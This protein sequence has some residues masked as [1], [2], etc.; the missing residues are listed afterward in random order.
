V[1]LA[2]IR[3]V[4]FLRFEGVHEIKLEPGAYS[5][6]ARR[7][8]DAE[9]SNWTGKSTI[10]QAVRF[11]L[12]GTIPESCLNR[13]VDGWITEGQ[14]EGEVALWFDDQGGIRRW[15]EPG[16]STQLAAGWVPGQEPA[17]QDAAQAL[18]LQKVGLSE[19]DWMSTCYLEQGAC[20]Q[21]VTE[22]AG[23]RTE[24]VTGWL[25]LEPLRRAHKQAGEEL[26]V[27]ERKIAGVA[28]KRDAVQDRLVRAAGGSTQVQ[29]TLDQWVD[30]KAMLEAAVVEWDAK[31]VAAQ[32]R[33]RDAE[34]A[35]AAR[36]KR[37]ELARVQEEGRHLVAGQ[38]GVSASTLQESHD[39]AS[40]RE[41]AARRRLNEAQAVVTNRRSVATGTFSGECPVA[42]IACPV[43]AKI[44]AMSEH[45]KRELDAASVDFRN[46]QAAVQ[47]ALDELSSAR[48][49]QDDHRRVQARI[50]ELGAR[51][52]RLKAELEGLPET[53]VSDPGDSLEEV[54]A[55]CYRTRASLR[56]LEAVIAAMAKDVDERRNLGYEL[57]LLEKDAATLREAQ[58]ILGKSGAQRRIAEG[59]LSQIEALAN[60]TLAAC[61][62]D[63]TVSLIWE[64]E[65][66]GIA[67]E[68]PK[69]GR[70]FSASA[71]EKACVECGEPRGKNR[72]QRLEVGLSRV[73]GAAKDLGGLAVALGASRWLRE[74]RG[75]QWG[76]CMLDE[77]TSALDKK[78]RRA[79]GQ[80]LRQMVEAA[81]FRQALV[82]SHSPDA[83]SALPGRIVVTGDA[84]RSWVEV[85]T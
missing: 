64:R 69:C 60:D 12:Y 30:E 43:T 75:F 71:K 62:V 1:I 38:R 2:G 58:A 42:G 39:A 31:L 85:R 5:V 7:T 37:E 23:A 46:A 49:A 9:E 56:E 20:S 53:R 45:G 6:V 54:T 35:A 18:V 17:R 76:T 14:K 55:K 3:L 25:R 65:G 82:V 19:E 22:E 34:A 68:C 10:L 33:A 83:V 50:V 24:K 15:R 73:S 80:H 81:G 78:N 59:A 70:A 51:S 77:V 32:E 57:G 74:G 28:A 44:N 40:G 67:D 8:D 63:L 79:V 52:K 27:L 61:G 13:G 26:A 48:R 72:V 84:K 11:A 21:F 41:V 29:A 36:L 66:K 4:N 16:K 47:V